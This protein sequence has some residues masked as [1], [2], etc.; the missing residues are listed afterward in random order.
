MQVTIAEESATRL[1]EYAS[2]PIRFRVSEVFD[3]HAIAALVQG[4]PAVTTP[5]RLPQW[6]D[7]DA[8]SGNHPTDW[9]LRFDV[10]RSTILAA[11]AQGQRVGGAALIFADPRIELLGD[12]ATCALLWDLRV[13]PTLRYQ[14]IGSALL[15][16]A[17]HV[18]TRLGASALRVETQ[19]V[20]VPACRF[21]ARNGF[22]LE[23]VVA[24]AYPDLPTEVQLL[25]RKDLESN[26]LGDPGTER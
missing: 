11:F 6:K 15:Q 17:E 8:H 25:W 1:A 24:D 3:D 22:R 7:Y 10:S 2:V 9:P 14:G 26:S 23:R 21:Y 13:A 12:C 4:L 19:Q 16:S 18:A 5:L 20:N